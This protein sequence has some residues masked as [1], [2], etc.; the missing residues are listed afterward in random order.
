MRDS[1]DKSDEHDWMLDDVEVS[2]D[3]GDKHL[4]DDEPRLPTARGVLTPAEIEALLRPD[5]PDD[6]GV[7]PEPTEILPRET[8]IFDD[9][10]QT[11]GDRERHTAAARAPRLSRAVADSTGLKAAISLADVQTLPAS[12]IRELLVGKAGA[13]A[14]FGL[15]SLETSAL[16]CLSPDLVDALIAAACGADDA[17]LYTQQDW[18]LS[19]MDCALL[20]QLLTPLAP[21]LGD[22]LGLHS[23]ETDM[24]Y[25]SSLIA[26]GDVAISEYSMVWGDRKSD[27][28]IV[29]ALAPTHLEREDD[30]AATASAAPPV[31]A[32]LTARIASLP[33]PLSRLTELKA[34]STL[35]LGLPSDQPVDVLSG[36]RDGPKVFEGQMGRRGNKLAVKI[37][38]KLKSA[39]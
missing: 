38:R 18:K 22:D 31:T 12:A 27:F 15:S 39:L 4:S 34:G 16:I 14:C 6:L 13:I 9:K 11:P 36:D 33:V 19:A 23:I 21:I 32:L 1:R 2:P 10:A 25:V 3:R 37:N 35:L 30:G 29:E 26:G 17:A 7:P 28:A 20:E 24:P 8:P 5:L